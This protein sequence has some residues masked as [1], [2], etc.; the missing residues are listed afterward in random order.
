MLYNILT[1]YGVTKTEA[2]D[3]IFV[4]CTIEA[5]TGCG[6]QFFFTD[7]QANTS[8]T[9]H[10]ADI[11]HLNQIDWDIILSGNFKK[12]DADVDRQRRYQA[13]FLVKYHV[14]VNCISAIAVYN[15]KT[16]TFVRNQLDK[17]GVLI[18]VYIKKDFY[19][20]R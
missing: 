8:I 6:N 14:P 3:I 1:G 5:L 12:T 13:E 15:K 9:S 17:A 20:N 2:E 18:P 16:E 19:F 10:Y 4:C 11:G 7:G